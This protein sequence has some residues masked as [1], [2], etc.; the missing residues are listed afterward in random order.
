MT[1]LFSLE[2]VNKAPASF[3]CQ[4]LVAFQKHYMNEI[5]LKQKVAAVLP[6]LQK[7]GFVA[8]PPPCDI[9]GKISDVLQA[10]DD[11]LVVAGD[12]LEFTEF[13]VGDDEFDY[14][15]KAFDKRLRNAPESVELLHK[16]AGQLANAEP[17][18]P[19]SLET[20]LRQF[21]ESEQTKIGQIVHALRVSLTGKSVGFGIFDTLAILGRDSCLKRIERAL[22]RLD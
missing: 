7:A 5:P 8:S 3:D 10:A 13:F 12:I 6:F 16:F 1:Q 9:S 11:R 19:D 4:K 2:R 20:L 17:F 18:D 15:E 21:V 22:Q 14:D